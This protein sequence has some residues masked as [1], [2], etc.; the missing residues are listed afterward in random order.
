MRGTAQALLMHNDL[1]AVERWS[2][3][4]GIKVCA[5]KQLDD[6]SNDIQRTSQH[7]AGLHALLAGTQD[8]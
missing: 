8:V 4:S 1:D 2:G 7:R 3:L 6:L 5:G